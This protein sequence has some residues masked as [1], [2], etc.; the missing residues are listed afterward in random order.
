MFSIEFPLWLAVIVWLESLSS[1]EPTINLLFLVVW[2]FYFK[3]EIKN[4]FTYLWFLIV[5]FCGSLIVWMDTSRWL[6]LGLCTIDVWSRFFLI[7]FYLIWKCNCSRWIQNLLSNILTKSSI[8]RITSIDRHLSRLCI[9]FIILATNTSILVG[10][11]HCLLIIFKSHHI[12]SNWLHVWNMVCSYTNLRTLPLL[13][14][15]YVETFVY[16]RIRWFILLTWSSP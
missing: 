5:L 15:I 8:N 16:C 3:F 14:I 12:H 11:T 13:S 1:L 9:I 4:I 6:T 2:D 10:L 7:I